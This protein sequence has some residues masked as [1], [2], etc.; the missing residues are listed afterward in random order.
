MLTDDY[1]I[2]TEVAAPCLSTDAARSSGYR[3]GYAA[4]VGDY[5]VACDRD[6]V[7][8]TYARKF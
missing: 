3:G 8:I 4:Y 6:L 1:G 5:N 2:P 7:S